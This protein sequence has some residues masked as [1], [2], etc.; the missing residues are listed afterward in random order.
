M[1]VNAGV[2]ERI[3]KDLRTLSE[4]TV[5][6]RSSRSMVAS[7]LLSTINCGPIISKHNI[8]VSVIRECQ[9]IDE[10]QSRATLE[11]SLLTILLSHPIESLPHWILGK[12]KQV[13]YNR[14]PFWTRW[15]RRAARTPF[16]P[17][18]EEN[19][20]SHDH[21]QNRASVL[22]RDGCGR[23]HCGWG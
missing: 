6:R 20:C 23:G 10:I 17:C 8:S 5:E 16:L 12:I 7:G 1:L 14:V 11:H 19:N 15:V 3:L 13:T 4:Y 9:T 21:S 18:Y 2:D 22:L